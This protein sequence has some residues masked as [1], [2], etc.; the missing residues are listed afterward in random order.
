[1]HIWSEKIVAGQVEASAVAARLRD[2]PAA[3]RV[4]LGP[5]LLDVR[6]FFLKNYNCWASWAQSRK[7][8]L[9]R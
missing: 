6:Q 8:Y 7:N 5:R 9:T 3:G 1:M 4:E 2:R